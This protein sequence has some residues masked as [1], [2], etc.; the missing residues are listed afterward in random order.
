M[1]FLCW[2]IGHRLVEMRELLIGG[3]L[4]Q[5]VWCG[6]ELCVHHGR[7]QVIPFDADVEKAEIDIRRILAIYSEGET[8][9]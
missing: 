2:I 6:S 9:P 7:Q 5:C 4:C 8:K 1:R 3:V